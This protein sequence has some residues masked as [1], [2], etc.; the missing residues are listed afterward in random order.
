MLPTASRENDL[1]VPSLTIELRLSPSELRAEIPLA[2]DGI[3]CAYAAMGIA[4]SEIEVL[5][6]LNCGGNVRE[7]S[8]DQVTEG[9]VE[10]ALL[11]SNQNG[12]PVMTL[13]LGDK[14]FD[15]SIAGSRLTDCVLIEL[16]FWDVAPE[17]I[18]PL[19]SAF[20]DAFQTRSIEYA[21]IQ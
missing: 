9:F 14:G 2:M 4:R 11:W 21:L 15:M 19:K 18:D 17:A 12:R 20:M 8:L 13:S 16:H 6:A 5:S 10:V 1:R 7:L 3:V